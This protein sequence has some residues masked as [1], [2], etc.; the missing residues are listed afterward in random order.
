MNQKVHLPRDGGHVAIRVGGEIYPP[1]IE[2]RLK[3][4]E[5]NVAWPMVDRCRILEGCDDHPVDRKQDKQRPDGQKGINHQLGHRRHLADGGRF[6]QS[7][8][9]A[10]VLQIEF[11]LCLVHARAFLI[12]PRTT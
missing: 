1:G 12:C 9:Q 10:A 7:F 4:E 2:R 6:E 8:E 5:R 3:I 11:R